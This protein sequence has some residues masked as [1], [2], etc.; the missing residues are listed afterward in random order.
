MLFTL[1]PVLFLDMFN[2]TNMRGKVAKFCIF[3]TVYRLGED[4]IGT[5]NF[6]EGDIPCLQ[7]LFLSLH[8]AMLSFYTTLFDKSERRFALQYSVSL[9]SEEE[10][11]QQYQRRPGHAVSVTGHGRHLESCLHTASSHFS[12][13][14]PLNVTPGFS[15]DIGQC[16]EG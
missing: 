2:I 6:S 15:T 1:T 12:L 13:P 11:Q 8:A 16:P 5:F 4:I 7:V 14:V 10:V 9:Q 3:K